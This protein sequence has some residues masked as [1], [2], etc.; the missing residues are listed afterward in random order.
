MH[1]LQCGNVGNILRTFHKFMTDLT[2]KKSSIDVDIISLNSK[3]LVVF[4]LI[5]AGQ[6]GQF[7]RKKKIIF[8]H[9]QIKM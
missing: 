9:S 3:V 1:M 4:H 8:F 5:E 2:E 6:I 7:G